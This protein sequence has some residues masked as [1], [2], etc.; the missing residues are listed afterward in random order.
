MKRSGLLDFQKKLVYQITQAASTVVPREVIL[1]NAENNTY[2]DF[3]GKL[4]RQK[5]IGNLEV[6][7]PITMKVLKK[8]KYRENIINKYFKFYPQNKLDYFHNAIQFYQCL[9][10]HPH[11]DVG[12]QE[13]IIDIAKFEVSVSKT[14]YYSEH[15]NKE[16]RS[17]DNQNS[18]C[19]KINLDSSVQLFNLKY[20]IKPIFNSISD[21]S[22]LPKSHINLIF[23]W[24]YHQSCIRAFELSDFNYCL[25]THLDQMAMYI[26]FIGMT[27]FWKGLMSIRALEVKT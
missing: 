20:N 14:I 7:L 9:T 4:I 27:R 22:I 26:K 16:N 24:D 25:L 23:C 21:F 17:N 5:R 3:L 8:N 13:K 11:K 12:F 10:E 1:N 18:T 2:I 19:L 6:L 15:G